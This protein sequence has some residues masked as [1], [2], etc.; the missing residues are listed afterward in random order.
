M[1]QGNYDYAKRLAETRC[2]FTVQG[3]L[4]DE[5]VLAEVTATLARLA[6]SY[7]DEDVQRMRSSEG[8]K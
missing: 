4:A 8:G 6:P 1:G 2:I 5:R 3:V 7:I